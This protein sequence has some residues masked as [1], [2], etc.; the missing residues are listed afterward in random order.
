MALVG[1]RFRGTTRSF[2]LEHPFRAPAHFVNR[3][4]PLGID[5]RT[6]KIV[7]FDPWILKL[8]KVIHSMI[9]LILGQ[10]DFGKSTLMKV[11][12][13]RLMA[14]QA[15]LDEQGYPLPMR[16]RMHDRKREKEA[17]EL[18]PITDYLV[19]QTVELNR[20]GFIN[21]FD[22]DLVLDDEGNI[23][24][25]DLLEIA[26]NAA[27]YDLGHMLS[28]F[29]P[30]SLQ[31]AVHKMIKGDLAMCTPERLSQLV[32]TVQGSDITD[33]F[34]DTDN[35]VNKMLASRN[36]AEEGLFV[37]QTQLTTSEAG[38]H[39]I[40]E[41][42]FQRDAS[43][44]AATLNRILQGDYGRIFGGT[45]SLRDVLSGEAVTFDWNGVNDKARG[46]LEAMLQKWQAIAADR[47]DRAL[48]P[49]INIADEAAE[50][51][52]SIQYARFRVQNIIKSR[53]YP[54]A[55]FE[56][57]Q[58]E[59]Q[60]LH[61]GDAGS[62]LRSLGTQISV[63]TGG[64]FV[65]RQESSNT[66]A[67]ELLS[68]MGLSDQDIH[69]STQLSIGCFLLLFG[70]RPAVPCQLI[71][72]ETERELVETNSAVNSMTER[73]D[74]RDLP[75]VQERL[76]EIRESGRVAVLDAGTMRH[77]AQQ[78]GVINL[79]KEEGDVPES[80]GHTTIDLGSSNHHQQITR[81]NGS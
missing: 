43:I 18:R 71:I 63:G 57:A 46:L 69:L 39:Y 33:Y 5:M 68:T 10:K 58:N 35:A 41:R 37:E 51:I 44:M 65:T 45:N 66:D 16:S 42:E 56:A 8:Q 4:M 48:I 80:N 25:A 40:D 24:E 14:L 50:G 53:A 3:G 28:G 77:L 13:L 11:L 23:S 29:Q 6:G 47:N 26:V 22:P 49:H 61:A 9:F 52:K 34:R 76:K 30:L 2:A 54:T 75:R 32:R 67:L 7:L 31:V 36:G 70:N 20:R 12:V 78:N 38:L 27:E 64:R 60:I 19:G 73:V 17:G 1:K 74:V 81:V 55:D 72:T 59:L 62:E 79:S 15:E 21:L